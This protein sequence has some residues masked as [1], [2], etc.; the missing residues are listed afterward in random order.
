M[1]MTLEPPA[2]AIAFM[3]LVHGGVLGGPNVTP[4]NGWTATDPA[5]LTTAGVPVGETHSVTLADGLKTY[6]PAR[7]KFGCATATLVLLTVIALSA[8]GLGNVV[9]PLPMSR[10]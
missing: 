9:L 8:F 7:C 1:T 6:S 3:P 10:F 5:P 2:D 4:C